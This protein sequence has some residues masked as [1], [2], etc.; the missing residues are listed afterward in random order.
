MLEHDKTYNWVHQITL[1]RNIY[2]SFLVSYF[3]GG[4]EHQVEHHLFP[5]MARY[6]Y[7]EARKI[8]EAFCVEKNIPYHQTT[9]LESLKQ[10]HESLKDDARAWQ[11]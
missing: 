1:T 5:N 8:V 4:L 2:P 7:A 9:W 10:I 6:K 11:N 3:L